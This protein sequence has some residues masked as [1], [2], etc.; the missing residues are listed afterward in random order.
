VATSYPEHACAGPVTICHFN[1][2][3]A[4]CF[5]QMSHFAIVFTPLALSLADSYSKNNK[6]FIFSL[7]HLSLK[8]GLVEIS[9]LKI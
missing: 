6:N 7:I 2:I 9:F 4:I 1:H 5:S 3:L 8:F